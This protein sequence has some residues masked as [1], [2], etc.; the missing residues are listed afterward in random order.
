MEVVHEDRQTEG[1]VLSATV[2]E[3]LV[4]GELGQLTAGSWLGVIDERRVTDAAASRI[5]RFDIRPTDP[6]ATA[7]SLSGGNQQKV[8]VARAL[9]RAPDVLV[10]A[11]PTRGVDPIAARAIHEQL[12]GA[13]ARGTALLVIGADLT[14]LRLLCRRILVMVRGRVVAS[15]P[16]TV[17]DEALG[18]AMLGGE[19]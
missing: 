6:E 5:A 14:E 19:A 17:D 3:N 2:R 16:P 11:H 7:R 1:L 4:L 12:L 15:F 18:A 10:I 8:V 9:A 13:A